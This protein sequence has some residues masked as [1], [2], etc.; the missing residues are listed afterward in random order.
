MTKYQEEVS[1]QNANENS[2]NTFSAADEIKKFKELLDSRIITQ[3][4]FEKKKKDLLGL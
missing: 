2:Q 3:D 4:E 1:M